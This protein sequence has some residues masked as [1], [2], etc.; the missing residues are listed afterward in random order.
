MDLSRSSFVAGL[1]ATLAVPPLWADAAELSHLDPVGAARGTPAQALAWLRAGNARFVVGG[2]RRLPTPSAAKPQRPWA[3]ALTC[4]DTRVA[5]EIVF[6]SLHFGDLF[7]CRTAGNIADADVTGSI[8]YAVAEFH[9][10][11]VVVIGH[12]GCGACDAAVSTFDGKELPPGSIISV[13]QSIMPAV[14]RVQRSDPDRMRKVIETNA[15][16]TASRLAKSPILA[17]AIANR[18]LRVAPGYHDLASGR[19]TIHA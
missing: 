11:F 16:L 15:A 2:Q 4:A 3:V 6:D 10:P 18:T 17:S 12:S 7:V 14:S 19:V 13:V 9:A 5:P 8:E 1:S